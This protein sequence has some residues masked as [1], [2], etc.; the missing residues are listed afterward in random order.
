VRDAIHPQGDFNIHD[1]VC[2]LRYVSPLVGRL[3]GH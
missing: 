2:L 3:R 1:F